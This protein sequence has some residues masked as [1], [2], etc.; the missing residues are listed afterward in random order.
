VSIFSVT[1]SQIAKGP[2]PRRD[3]D[4]SEFEGLAHVTTKSVAQLLDISQDNARDYVRRLCAKGCL[5][6]DGFENVVGPKAVRSVKR[7]RIIRK[8]DHGT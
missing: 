6:H 3:A 2:S 1:I 8:E 5:V 7:F 4:M